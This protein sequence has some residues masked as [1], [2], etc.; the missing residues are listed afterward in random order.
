VNVP[1]PTRDPDLEARPRRKPFVA[2][3]LTVAIVASSLVAFAV[4]EYLF[5]LAKVNERI[6]RG[7]WW[8]LVTVALVHGGLLHLAFNAFAL[9][10]LGT[11]AEMVYGRG[12]L[13]AIFVLGTALA[14]T[15]SLVYTE[16]NGVGA[17]GG[18]FAIVGAILVFAL[19]ARGTIP[20]PI[21]KRLVIDMTWIVGVNVLFGLS[22]PY[23]D[24]AA[25]LGGLAAGA[26][27]GAALGVPALRR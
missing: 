26:A 8:R 24:N 27:I 11:L 2:R 14:T 25:H 1:G 3:A 7:E 10:Q 5:A 12:R 20:E 4:P 19:R 13:I 9:W 23:V 17:S 22:V 18:V 16:G 21:R 15:A 6:L